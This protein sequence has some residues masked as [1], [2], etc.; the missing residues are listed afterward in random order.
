MSGLNAIENRQDVANLVHLF[1]SKVR[2]NEVLAPIFSKHIK[3]H[4][5]QLHISKL[6][7]FW[8]SNLFKKAG[9]KGNP[10]SHHIKVDKAESYKIEPTH[11]GIWLQLWIESV[12]ELFQGEIATQA[13]FIAR[14]MSTG[15]YIAMWNHRPDIF[16]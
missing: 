5:W 6:T 2:K 15:Q 8:E 13:K 1:Y 9:Y 16:K 11:F 4:E 14:K 12:D 7:D 3:D 10:V